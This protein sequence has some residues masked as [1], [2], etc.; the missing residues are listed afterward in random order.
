MNKMLLLSLAVL[1]S[2]L[3]ILGPSPA[4]AQGATQISVTALDEGTFITVQETG[5][6]DVVSLYRLRGDRIYLVD[7]VFN[8]TSRDVNLPKRYLHRVEVDNR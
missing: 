5:S 1:V 4:W 7:T 3:P 6:G 8:S 2:I